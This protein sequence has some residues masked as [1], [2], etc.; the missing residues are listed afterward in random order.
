VVDRSRE[1]DP[2]CAEERWVCPEVRVVDVEPADLRTLTDPDTPKNDGVVDVRA[3]GVGSFTDKD[4]VSAGVDCR[5]D[6]GML[7]GNDGAACD[8]RLEA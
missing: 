6:G 5:L 8:C 1:L 3:L 4:G 7:V 2:A